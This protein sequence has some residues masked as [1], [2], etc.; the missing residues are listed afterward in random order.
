M[1]K[2]R[3]RLIIIM[4]MI[5]YIM[6]LSS[7]KNT[8]DSLRLRILSNSNNEIDIIEKEYVKCII[9]EIYLDKGLID[10]NTLELD[11]L[12]RVDSRLKHNIKVEYKIESFPAKSYKGKFIPSGNYPT[13]LITIGE[14][15]GKNFWTML[16]PDF[17]NIS[18]DENNEVEYRSY[19]Y[20][21]LTGK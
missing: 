12:S 3:K 5:F 16:Y 7:C 6:I 20:D 9:K 2:I 10:Y 8:D 4:C 15:L 1:G 18:F 11:I 13:I 21:K 17:F 14:G 19:I